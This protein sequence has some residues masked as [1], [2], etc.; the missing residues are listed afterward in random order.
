MFD[1]KSVWD[2]V[3]SLIVE[4]GWTVL[5]IEGQAVLEGFAVSCTNEEA[6]ATASVEVWS[7]WKSVE[8]E[9]DRLPKKQ[10]SA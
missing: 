7:L 9:S 5:D 8:D 3:E 10:I 6:T 2:G 4:V 1:R